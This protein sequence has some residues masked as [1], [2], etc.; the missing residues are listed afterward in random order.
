M[1]NSSFTQQ[2]YGI[3]NNSNNT[4][5]NVDIELEDTKDIEGCSETEYRT[6]SQ[7]QEVSTPIH[8]DNRAVIKM[9]ANQIISSRNKHMDIKMFYVQERVQAKDVHLTS[10][11]TKDQR[12][13]LFTKNLPFPVFSKFRSMLL[14]PSTYMET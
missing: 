13:D 11:S 10:I 2:R 3:P 9:A 5:S 7:S 1:Y 8:E 6:T 14:Q 4:N 12:A